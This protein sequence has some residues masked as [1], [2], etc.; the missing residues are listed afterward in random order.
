MLC[1]Y[2]HNFGQ[3]FVVLFDILGKIVHMVL[4]CDVTINDTYYT[5]KLS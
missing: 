3:Y 2:S 5:Y 4:V 1:L